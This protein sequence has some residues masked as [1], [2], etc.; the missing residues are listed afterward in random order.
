MLPAIVRF[1]AK[2]HLNEW[3]PFWLSRF[4]NQIQTGF[5]RG[6]VALTGVARNA[7]AHDVFPRGRPAAIARDD[8]VE[9]QITPIEPVS[10]VLAGVF[11]TFKNIVP[12]KLHFLPGKPVVRQQQNDARN[13]QLKGH[14]R[15]GVRVR[16][17]LG[18]ILPLA[19]AESLETVGV[20][21]VN[22][23]RVSGEE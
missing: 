22:Y 3:P 17:G 1:H 7:R 5:A 9:I 15:D 18:K 12:R 2:T 21:I 6:A 16:F 20:V 4:S 14:R 13:A 23:L 19:K 8:V 11:I 10:A